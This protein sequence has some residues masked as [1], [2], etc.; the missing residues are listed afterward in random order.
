[1]LKRLPIKLTPDVRRTVCLNFETEN[2]KTILRIYKNVLSLSPEDTQSTYDDFIKDFS[3]RHQYFFNILKTTFD[4]I[5]RILPADHQL[6]ELQQSIVASYFVKEY[7]VEAAALF[8]PSMVIHPI[9]DDSART[10]IL[11][12]L[13]ATGEGHISSIE[14]VDGYIGV[15]GALEL[16]KRGTRCS[17]AQIKT[18]DMEKRVIE[19]DGNILL[20]EQVIFPLTKD[21]SNG[22]EDVRFVRFEKDNGEIIY[23]GTFTAYDGVHIK[24]KLISTF[25]FKK[26]TICS[27]KGSAVNDKGM[28]PFP[29]KI[30]NRY[31]MI[32]RQD[33][34]NLRIMYSDDMLCWEN[35]KILQTPELPWQFGKLGNCG[36]PIE[37]DEGW[38]LMVH[39]VGP[40]R[41][42]VMGA[43]LLD[44]KNPEKII[45]RT[46]KYM[47]S[48]T[49]DEREGY[50]PN[51]VYSCGSICHNGILYIPF[52][53]S[54][55]SSGIVTT[56]VQEL[57]GSMS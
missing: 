20:N 40:V 15:N 34:E 44:K 43:Y 12:S 36:S 5:K 7:S 29:R 56:S 39:G 42:Y 8:N 3:F 57:L 41:K 33:G 16:N 51:V 10:K 53:I 50:V 17:L 26:F 30:N 31:A 48:A 52:A 47:L 38:L 2:V 37:I 9:Q 11:M 28:A 35:S 1:M 21:E 45:A 23:Y 18:L 55:I 32:S 49:D 6:S 24:S 46:K 27:M 13:R 54:D 25:D 19:F 22:I 14:F 4:Q